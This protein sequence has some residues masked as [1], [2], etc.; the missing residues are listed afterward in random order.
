[1]KKKHLLI[2][3]IIIGFIGGTIGYL[4]Y[5]KPHI[6]YSKT[7][8][9]I[10]TSAEIII[11]DYKSDEKQANDKYSGKVIEIT[12]LPVNLSKLPNGKAFITLNDNF[13]GVICQFDSGYVASNSNLFN[14]PPKDKIITIKGRCDGYLTDVRLSKCSI[15]N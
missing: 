9:E 6:D 15:I 1:M 12:G 11:N 3:I 4:Q 13:M 7:E 14:K 2:G 8:P 10:R 5:N